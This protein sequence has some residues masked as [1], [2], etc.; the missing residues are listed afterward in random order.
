M[1]EPKERPKRSKSAQDKPKV[2]KSHIPRAGASEPTLEKIKPP[3]EWR[4]GK[5]TTEPEAPP[6]PRV[7]K[8]IA[9]ER[10][11]APAGSQ[12]PEIA[13]PV[14]VTATSSGPAGATT[15]E[16]MPPATAAAPVATFELPQRY[17]VDRLVVLVRDPYWVYAWW[18]LTEAR[19]EDGRRQV[20][21]GSPTVLRVYDIS[22]IDWNGSN[23]HS[24]FDIEVEDLAGNWYI[25]LG[26]PGATFCAELGLR[27]ADGRFLPLLRSNTV[28]LPRDSMSPVV[29]EEW[30]VVEEDYRTLFDLAGG[31]SIGLGSGEIQRL[32][33]QRLKLEL[34]SGGVSSF[35]VSSASVRRKPS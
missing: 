19:L 4:S 28:T 23:H 25:E 9:A 31:G 22:N 20:G 32:L 24:A 29:D 13:E 26:K 30:M 14:T 3:R 6:A 10:A 35:G 16:P 11:A 18:E 21:A 2:S 5:R 8:H 34:A 15:P 33:E 12:A 7:V 17:G 27:T 1:T